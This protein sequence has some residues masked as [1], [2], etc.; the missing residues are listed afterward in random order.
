M[1]PHHL[2]VAENGMLGLVADATFAEVPNADVVV[3][4]GGVGVRPL[5]QDE[6]VLEW[7][8]KAHASN[9]AFRNFYA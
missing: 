2:P 5:L 6:K 8:R 9:A 3:F 7:V 4:P 1:L